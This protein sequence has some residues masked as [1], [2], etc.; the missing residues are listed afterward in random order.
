MSLS[1]APAT[2]SLPHLLL[3]QLSSPF[4]E[5]NISL[6]QYNMGITSADT[7]REETR[8]TQLQRR[9]GDKHT[10]RRSEPQTHLDGC[11]GKRYLPPPINVRVENTKNVLELFRNDQR[12]EKKH[13]TKVWIQQSQSPALVLTTVTNHPDSMTCLHSNPARGA[14]DVRRLINMSGLHK[15]PPFILAN[16]ANHIKA[17]TTAIKAIRF[18]YL[19]ESPVIE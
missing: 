3:S 11:D 17:T 5:I 16:R 18:C 1:W 8:F 10:E 12:L 4:V 7:L 19:K 15:L 14:N 6:P 13:Q 2:G 9:H